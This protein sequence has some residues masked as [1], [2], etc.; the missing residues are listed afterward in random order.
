MVW[1]N[2]LTESGQG[3]YFESWK[4]AKQCRGPAAE[5]I[6]G[7][8]GDGN[9]EGEVLVELISGR[10]QVTFVD[11]FLDPGPLRDFLQRISEDEVI[12]A[13]RQSLQV[14]R[15]QDVSDLP[16]FR[17]DRPEAHSVTTRPKRDCLVRE[18]HSVW[19]PA[20]A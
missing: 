5:L 17:R 13:L 2:V 7:M 4:R 8:I 9:Y 3:L 16:L 12:E 14:V 10:C 6:S 1:L 19:H 18:E 15:D 11:R 20:V